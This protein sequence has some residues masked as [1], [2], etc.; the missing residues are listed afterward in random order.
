MWIQS[1]NGASYA[2][3]MYSEEMKL[4]LGYNQESLDTIG[5][6]KDVGENVGIV[7]G[8]LYDV[9]QPSWVL[10]VGATQSMCGYFLLWLTITHKIARPKLWGV[11]TFMWMA[12][13]GQTFFNTATIVTCVKL[14]PESRGKAI[15][16]L[17]GMLGLSSAILSQIFTGI[18]GSAA[19]KSAFLLLIS[20][21]PA[22]VGFSAMF[23]VRL[24]AVDNDGNETSES[25]WFL[26]VMT[27]SSFLA[28]FLMV[29]VVI[30]NF[31]L[32]STAVDRSA[33]IIVIIILLLMMI[34]PWRSTLYRRRETEDFSQLSEKL[35]QKDTIL[36]KKDMNLEEKDGIS[37][38]R[39]IEFEQTGKGITET[40]SIREEEAGDLPQHIKIDTGKRASTTFLD[41]QVPKIE[42]D[43]ALCEILVSTN[44]LLLVT[45]T[46]CAMGAGFTAINNM[47][48]IGFSQGY[49]PQHIDT[50]VSLL[51]I[52]GFAGRCLGGFASDI[53]L[54]TKSIPRP[55][56]IV[57]ALCTLALGL[58]LVALAP[59][60]CLY[61]ASILIG[62]GHGAQWSLVP[63]VTSELFGLQHYGTLY[64]AVTALNPIASYILSICVVGFFY[65]QETGRQ[66]QRL[67]SWQYPLRYDPFSHLEPDCEGQACFR[68]SFLI[69]TA[70]CGLGCVAA[71]TLTFRTRHFYAIRSRETI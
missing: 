48:Q 23:L 10:A 14:F 2:F 19:R 47:G 51:S 22:F 25:Y 67:P 8:L 50:V 24:D 55:A 40:R 38:E 49:S 35:L 39:E 69:M 16:L 41:N 61:L 20:W 17:K 34:V 65:D 71:V 18:Y 42:Q 31:L 62:V 57:A 44:F 37:E 9:V 29:V 15:G 53:L 13:N 12:T 58:A 52:S 5:F 11:C 26:V 4:S 63:A 54:H 6:W 7:A 3:G 60:A 56:F 70:V 64:N 45:A 27:L 21:V 32:L 59:P 46:L 66:Q 28:T 43:L 33:S 68:S 1:C 30:D 36:G